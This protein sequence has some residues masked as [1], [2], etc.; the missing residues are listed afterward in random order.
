MTVTVREITTF[1]IKSFYNH[2]DLEDLFMFETKY[3]STHGLQCDILN[4]RKHSSISQ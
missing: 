1:C 3:A 4:Q 2:S